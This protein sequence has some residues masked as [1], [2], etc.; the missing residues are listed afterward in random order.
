MQGFKDINGHSLHQ[1][2]DVNL[3]ASIMAMGV[4]LDPECPI[5]VME[6]ANG[7]YGSWRLLEQSQDG[8]ES[9]FALMVAWANPSDS[10]LRPDHPFYDVC[11]FIKARPRNMS[12]TGD[13]LSFAVDYIKDRGEPLHGL[14][15][16][17]DIPSFV[18]ALPDSKASYILAYI[19]NRQTC[20]NLFRKARRKLY[21]EAQDGSNTRRALID[22]T[23]PRW[24][25][26]ELLSR[27]QG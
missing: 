18:D 15:S 2:G 12:E 21:Y 22:S 11:A 27:L 24:Q 9:T 3:V 6:S 4:P 23:L 16:V 20:F 1:C 8:A 25:A 26:K 10:P 17:D 19:F 7:Q 13:I 14:R 5:A